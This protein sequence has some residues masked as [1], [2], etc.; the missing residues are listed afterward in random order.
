MELGGEHW[1]DVLK[2]KLRSWFYFPTSQPKCPPT[3]TP[4]TADLQLIIFALDCH[5]TLIR[6]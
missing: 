5:G 6:Y 4:S 3:P 2:N 1:M